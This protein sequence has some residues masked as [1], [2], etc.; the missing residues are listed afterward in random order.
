MY[1]YC[2]NDFES[3]HVTSYD[4]GVQ[5]SFSLILSTPP[6]CRSQVAKGLSAQEAS[7]AGDL[8]SALCL[9]TSCAGTDGGLKLLL[10]LVLRS[11]VDNV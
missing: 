2:V 6:L 8:H 4:L 3:S 7:N 9:N 1:T 5:L 11:C 10:L